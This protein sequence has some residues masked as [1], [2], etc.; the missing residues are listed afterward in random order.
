MN[1]FNDINEQLTHEDKV[2]KHVID[3]K[4]R[5]IKSLRRFTSSQK[6][7]FDMIWN[8]PEF[9]AQEIFD[10]FGTDAKDLFIAS[11]A[12]ENYQKMAVGEDN[13]TPLKVPAEFVIN[14]DGTVTVGDKIDEDEEIM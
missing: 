10:I 4:E 9:T 12:A 5:I 7:V 14:D 11:A 8:H 13:Y 1:I 3:I 6:T 2:N